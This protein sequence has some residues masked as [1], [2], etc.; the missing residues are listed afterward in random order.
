MA[1]QE[2][3]ALFWVW[4]HD[5]IAYGPVE[6]PGLVTW[7]RQ[8][9]VGSAQWIFVS[10]HGGWIKA[11]EMPELR[12]F[13]AELAGGPET[14][15]GEVR[16]SALKPENLRRIR[17]FAEMDAHQLRS[18]VNYMELVR[19]NKFARLFDKGDHG[20]AMYF[21][22]EGE[23]RAL[24]L[25]D[26]KETTLFTMRPGDSFGEI[27]LL[28]QGPRSATM[29]ANEDSTLLRLPS[30]A[31]ERIVREAP[32]LAAPFLL[33]LSRVIAHRSLEIGRKYENSIRSARVLA[34]LRF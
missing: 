16:H 14:A 19:V 31:F 24:T 25:L 18:L 21:V 6:L 22:L 32:A 5:R 9:R 34:E 29:V 1:E 27:A 20:D 7:V 28:I 26:G 2:L 8:G 3:A 13:F 17:L 30:A 15:T 10:D 33:A 11:G 23:V 12:M 4:G